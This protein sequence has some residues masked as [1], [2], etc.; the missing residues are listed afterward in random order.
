MAVGFTDDMIDDYDD[1]GVIDQES[2]AKQIALVGEYPYD[3]IKDS[4]KDQFSNY[5]KN[6]D[7]TDYVDIFYNELEKSYDL[8]ND[9]N[10]DLVLDNRDLLGDV[11]NGMNDDFISFMKEL[12]YQ[13]MTITFSDIEEE[14]YDYENIKN[15]LSVAYDFFILNAKNNFKKAISNDILVR[16]K[17]ETFNSDDEYYKRINELMSLYTPLIAAISPLNYIRYIGDD[18]MLDLFE[19]GSISGNFLRKYSPKLYQNEEF[20]IEI[21]TNVTM[22]YDLG[23][24]YNKHAGE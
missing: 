20:K 21:I 9:D 2:I 3:T 5:I 15:E 23:K 12:F 6:E 18:N 13:Y 11:L 17:S 19:N 1:E 8:I 10:S 7:M 4:I 16:I 24:E 22:L 14:D